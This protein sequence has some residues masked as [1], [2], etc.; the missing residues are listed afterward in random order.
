MGKREVG[1]GIVLAIFG[2]AAGGGV[3]ALFALHPEWAGN[4]LGVFVALSA[5]CVL[6]GV[7][8]VAVGVTERPIRG[9]TPVS[10]GV[11]Y[12]HFREWGRSVSADGGGLMEQINAGLD[13][14]HE[15]AVNARVSVWGQEKS[16][17]PR[18]KIDPRFWGF[19]EIDITRLMYPGAQS[20]TTPDHNGQQ[21]T[22]VDL[23]ISR[24]EFEREW[25]PKSLPDRVAALL[26]AAS[27]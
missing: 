2:V 24:A 13:E 22:Y 17:G 11:A 23:M 27:G 9:D 15:A 20:R 21:P 10:E 12:V 6:G 7:G 16:Y 19:E 1:F 14:V 5:L 25:P 18:T 26:R 8:L 4:L 3:S